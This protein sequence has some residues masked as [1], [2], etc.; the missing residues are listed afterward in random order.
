VGT[1][2]RQKLFSGLLNTK[3]VQGGSDSKTLFGDKGRVKTL[4]CKDRSHIREGIK[5]LSFYE[6]RGGNCDTGDH[7]KKKADGSTE[8]W[9]HASTLTHRGAPFVNFVDGAS[10]AGKLSTSYLGAVDG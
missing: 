5:S 7:S 10:C 3:R 8:E 6:K 2:L 4:R 9:H 1:Y